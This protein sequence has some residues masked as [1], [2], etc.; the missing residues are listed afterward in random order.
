[1]KNIVL[2]CAWLFATWVWSLY[3]FAQQGSTEPDLAGLH[4]IRARFCND[5]E[6]IGW[7]KSV[8]L[9]WESTK[10]VDVCLY[11]FNTHKEPITVDV[12]VVDG[13]LTLDK[14]QKPACKDESQKSKTMIG[15]YASFSWNQQVFNLDPESVTKTSFSLDLPDHYAGKFYA[16]VTMKIHTEKTEQT[17]MFEI[18]KRRGYPFSI[19]IDGNVVSSLELQSLDPASTVTPTWYKM[20]IASGSLAILEKTNTY[21]AYIIAH[22][23]WNIPQDMKAQLEKSGTGDIVA[24]RIL[25]WEVS[26]V[27]IPLPAMD[28]KTT[29]VDTSI[30]VTTTPVI[31]FESEKITDEVRSPTQTLL[32]LESVYISPVLRWVTWGACAVW[33]LLLL[34]LFGKKEKKKEKLITISKKEYKKL[35]K[36]KKKKKKSSS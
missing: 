2:C 31:D 14:Q 8:A 1:M 32:S 22:N 20:I 6:I 23:T 17:E 18:V 15:Q 24:R 21:Y 5:T 33:F 13:T 25:P 12:N 26:D 4:S 36:K 27:L 28:R 29:T 30:E 10:D 3:S 11:L 16:C 35:I 7:T 19:V 9:T 34:L